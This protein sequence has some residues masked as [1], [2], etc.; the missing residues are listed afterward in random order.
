MFLI[1]FHFIFIFFLFRRVKCDEGKPFCNNCTKSS[2]H[3]EGYAPR[4]D[5][6]DGLS[7]RLKKR[8]PLDGSSP[9]IK[10]S[11]TSTISLTDNDSSSSVL[12]QNLNSETT[13]DAAGF[14]AF[15]PETPTSS[16]DVMT[17]VTNQL[18]SA[19]SPSSSTP[20][21]PIPLPYQT[22]A[23]PSAPH[24]PNDKIEGCVSEPL[25]ECPKNLQLQESHLS[26]TFSKQ[27]QQQQKQ[28]QSLGPPQ[29]IHFIT[30]NTLPSNQTV[31]S[32]ASTNSNSS[33]RSFSSNFSGHSTNTISSPYSP[34][35]TDQ[36]EDNSGQIPL[37]THLGRTQLPDS[38]ISGI[39][40]QQQLPKSHS[41]S[42]LQFQALPDSFQIVPTYKE[43]SA[44]SSPHTMLYA[45]SFRLHS[46]LTHYINDWTSFDKSPLS[47]SDT[48]AIFRHFI[49][50]QAASLDSAPRYDEPN[51]SNIFFHLSF[52]NNDPHTCFG[53]YMNI[54]NQNSKSNAILKQ[55]SNEDRRG[56][57]NFWCYD[58]PLMSQYY[59]HVL[60]SLLALSALH[61]SNLKSEHESLF[62]RR[63][64]F[65]F[66]QKG[67]KSLRQDL[68]MLRRP[69]SI[70]AL[71]TSLLL[72]N[73]ELGYGDVKKWSQHM[74]GAADIIKALDMGALTAPARGVFERMKT[75][76][77]FDHL[78][79]NINCDNSLVLTTAEKTAL[80]TLDLL[81]SFK[82]MEV[83]HGAIA[84]CKSLLPSGF[85]DTIPVRVAKNPRITAFDEIVRLISSIT[86]WAS[87]ETNRK[88]KLS[89][90]S[91]STITRINP[92]GTNLEEKTNNPE[93]NDTKTF[94]SQIST[95]D[96]SF[97]EKSEHKSSID[98]WESY[99][100]QMSDFEH[101][102]KNFL[103]PIPPTSSAYNPSF[104]SS[105]MTPFGPKYQ[106]HSSY[107]V[108]LT[109]FLC[110][111]W[112]ILLRNNPS[113]FEFGFKLIPQTAHITMPYVIRIIR[114]LPPHELP[115]VYGRYINT[116]DQHIENIFDGQISRMVCTSMVPV[117][118]A[119]VQLPDPAQQEYVKNWILSVGKFTG[120]N[121]HERIMYGVESAWSIM[122]N[123]AS[124]GS[125]E[126]EIQSR[127]ETQS[128][129]H[130]Q[131]HG[132]T[133]NHNGSNTSKHGT[134]SNSGYNK[135]PAT[136]STHEDMNEMDI[137]YK[138]PSTTK[139]LNSTSLNDSKLK[140]QQY[141]ENRNF[142]SIDED[143]ELLSAVSSVD[144]DL[145]FSSDEE[146]EEDDDCY[147]GNNNKNTTNTSSS[148][149]YTSTNG[150]LPP[151]STKIA[152]RRVEQAKGIF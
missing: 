148:T 69:D 23:I 15:P 8:S 55:P 67:V 101:R 2:R 36:C 77:N 81:W 49:D 129:L 35:S 50:F 105:H 106:Y 25:A 143:L 3:C 138:K 102:Y 137:D 146:E 40:K 144:S 13:I 147:S 124:G 115:G 123:A 53:N 4:L 26:N 38:Q 45:T 34:E 99:K 61:L 47:D 121:I 43:K 107:D 131:K 33:S 91:N 108:F 113:F 46:N 88:Q 92:N 150:G 63:R 51:P 66:Y 133:V 103:T 17:F 96:M 141:T 21:S 78:N 19:D 59:P 39:P 111:G 32:P 72:A 82:E 22:S 94:G 58:V 142:V 112:I 64:S 65:F 97:E 20:K 114:S 134:I 73:F 37:G 130:S 18:V 127:N 76:R 80:Q 12:F 6:R 28:H 54:E 119:A 140:Q 24:S 135:S 139:T 104:N 11:V 95:I 10:F 98:Q 60:Y 110:F 151:M 84:N 89:H 1:N 126:A 117:F 48:F 52:A 9:Q 128:K 109:N 122:N 120:W 100:N 44:P 125:P 14:F 68:L 83:M 31:S 71:V 70:A 87:C 56:L 74:C 30:P 85:W 27:Q 93:K 118:F 7:Q 152:A 75:T 116:Y 16:N 132:K 90:K 29:P 5:F 79:D 41:Y 145:K 136:N 62:L 57:E 86:D 149:N 42:N